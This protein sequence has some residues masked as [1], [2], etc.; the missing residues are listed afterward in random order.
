MSMQQEVV[1]AP[2]G[3]NTPVLSRVS[4]LVQGMLT[5]AKEALQGKR[6]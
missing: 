1:S 5:T 3:K 4:A 2:E 6:A